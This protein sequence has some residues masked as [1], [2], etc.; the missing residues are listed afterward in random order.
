M[1][2]FAD[3]LGRDFFAGLEE[4][5]ARLMGF[6]VALFLETVD[7]AGFRAIVFATVARFAVGRAGLDFNA[8][9]LTDDVAAD[10]R[11]GARD[12]DRL[13]FFV[14]GLLTRSGWDMCRVRHPQPGIER[15]FNTAH[16][17]N[18]RIKGSCGHN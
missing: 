18:Q 9:P 7:L 12:V 16:L 15:E 8:R 10:F 13:K 2:V 3:T 14:M 1:L 17:V 5:A 11:A 6:F 4:M